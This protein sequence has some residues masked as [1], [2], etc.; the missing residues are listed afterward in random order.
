VNNS[1]P[2]YQFPRTF[3]DPQ[4]G[5]QGNFWTDNIPWYLDEV[6]PPPPVETLAN[7]DWVLVPNE[8]FTDT[9]R[10]GKWDIGEPFTDVNGNG[11]WD[12]ART[13]PPTAIPPNNQ[14]SLDFY[15]QG[16]HLAFLDTPKAIFSAVTFLVG[17]FGNNTYDFLAGFSW[18]TVLSPNGS[19]QVTNLT[20]G[21]LFTKQY[22]KLVERDFGYK[23]VEKLPTYLF[24]STLTS[25]HFASFGISPVQP[26]A[27]FVAWTNNLPD[28]NP[29]KKPN[30]ILGAFD[31]LGNLITVNDNGGPF[32]NN[33]GSGLKRKVNKDGSINL[34]VT[35]YKDF[36][37][38]GL[39]DSSGGP[40]NGGSGGGGC[41]RN[42][43]HP[44][45]GNYELAV[46]MYQ[47][48]LPS[49]SSIGTNATA[50]AARSI[51]Q[52][53][54]FSESDVFNIANLYSNLP[55]QNLSANNSDD[56]AKAAEEA[57]EPTTAFGA[58]LALCGLGALKKL[59]NRKI[60][61]Q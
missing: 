44:Q 17:D 6:P 8:P 14:T 10:N 20:D 1:S 16:S 4:F 59:K 25:G 41:V 34:K 47:D 45:V 52:E 33:L 12:L 54:S 35:G 49:R 26:F 60:K 23:K 55:S 42:A 39:N 28:V 5:G 21:A 40:C 22:A 43:P 27:P 24:P 61:Q 56:D 18:S 7:G 31:E 38:D 2:S 32:G 13:S 58:L 30:T 37:F 53:Q 50:F 48:Y 3:I 46:K 11:K 29:P 51:N 57:P 19:T 9:N 15:S 36:N